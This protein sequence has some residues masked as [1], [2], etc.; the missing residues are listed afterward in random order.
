MCYSAK[1]AGTD[2]HR[3]SLRSLAVWWGE[4]NSHLPGGAALAGLGWKRGIA[5]ACIPL[6]NTAGGEN[7]VME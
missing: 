5:N 4:E 2:H 6:P 7:V 1:R 3:T